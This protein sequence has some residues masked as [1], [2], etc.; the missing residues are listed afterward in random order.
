MDLGGKAR[1]ASA[2]PRAEPAGRSQRG[3]WGPAGRTCLPRG[4]GRVFEEKPWAAAPRPLAGGHRRRRP[5][6]GFFLVLQIFLPR[7]AGKLG[8]GPGEPTADPSDEVKVSAPP[9][10]LQRLGDKLQVGTA[11]P[12]ARWATGWRQQGRSHRSAVRDGGGGRGGDPHSLRS[13]GHATQSGQL[14][15]AKHPVYGLAFGASWVDSTHCPMV[16]SSSIAQNRTQLTRWR[17][18]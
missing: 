8:Q 1:C 3:A 14:P 15:E 16:G 6:A 12:Q 9:R 5:H 7:L 18:I 17:S 2:L 4:P 13:H 11:S 10:G